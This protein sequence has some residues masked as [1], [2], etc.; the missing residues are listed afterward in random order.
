VSLRASTKFGAE[1]IRGRLRFLC[2][3]SP[4]LITR[5]DLARSSRRGYATATKTREKGQK[6]GSDSPVRWRGGM[7]YF[8]SRAVLPCKPNKEPRTSGPH[9]T[10]ASS[11]FP[12]TKLTAKRRSFTRGAAFNFDPNNKSAPKRSRARGR[13]VTASLV[14]QQTNRGCWDFHFYTRGR[15]VLFAEADPLID[16]AASSSSLAS[17]NRRRRSLSLFLRLN[18]PP[19]DIPRYALSVN[20]SLRDI[21]SYDPSLRPVETTFL[22]PADDR[23]RKETIRLDIETDKPQRL[24]SARHARGR[25]V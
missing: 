9:T 21:P 22:K 18:D 2:R 14:G 11:I 5:R 3:R 17:T 4:T 15:A 12:I 6:R 7:I 23:E 20:G 24:V 1:E 8:S 25:A 13:T 10:A 19:C 16:P